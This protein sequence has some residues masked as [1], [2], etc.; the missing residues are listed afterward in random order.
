[1]NLSTTR[2][3]TLLGTSQSKSRWIQF[4]PRKISAGENLTKEFQASPSLQEILTKSITS[5]SCA[6]SRTY[7][8]CNLTIWPTSSWNLFTSPNLDPGLSKILNEWK[9]QVW[10]CLFWTLTKPWYTLWTRETHPTWK[11]NSSF[12]F[13]AL[14][15]MRSHCWSRLTWGLISESLCWSCLSNFN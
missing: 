11:V 10:S 14:I 5:K 8:C 4:Q 2:K 6:P 9:E 3:L 12:R 7:T 15:L 13:P 1:M